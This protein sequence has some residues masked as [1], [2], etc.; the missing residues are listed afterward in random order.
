MRL[1]DMR[2]MHSIQEEPPTQ[3]GGS[4]T[5]GGSKRLRAYTSRFLKAS[6]TSLKPFDFTAQMMKPMT[7]Q[8]TPM[9]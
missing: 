2:P 9:M 6:G 8:L 4:G 7:N 5:Q 3:A 1:R